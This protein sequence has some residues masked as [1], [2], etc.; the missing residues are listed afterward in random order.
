M[1]PGV[2]MR[3][4]PEI[5][6]HTGAFQLPDVPDFIIA[7]IFIPIERKMKV[8]DSSCLDVPHRF[9][10]IFFSKRGQKVTDDF[11]NVPSLVCGK[12]T[13]SDSSEAGF[14]FP[15]TPR[16]FFLFRPGSCPRERP[17][18]VCHPAFDRPRWL[19]PPDTSRHCPRVW[20]F[21]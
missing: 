10:R 19:S 14:F 18:A 20:G 1:K 17:R 3:Q 2:D 7:E 16:S 4:T 15:I 12:I 21:R 11:H 8:S 9:L 6:D 13:Y 5:R